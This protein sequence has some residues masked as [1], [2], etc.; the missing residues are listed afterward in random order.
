MLE[1]IGRCFQCNQKNKIF[2]NLSY[3]L[4]SS[5]KALLGHVTPSLRAFTIDFDEKEKLLSTCFFMME[6]LMIICLI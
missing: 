4:L 3:L 2:F 5:E 6:K 1:R